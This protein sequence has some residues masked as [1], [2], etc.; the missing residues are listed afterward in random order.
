MK[1]QYYWPCFICSIVFVLF[2]AGCEKQGQLTLRLLSAPIDDPYSELDELRLTVV[3]KNFQGVAYFVADPKQTSVEVGDIDSKDNH[4]ILITGLKNK[5]IIAT[6]ASRSLNL[7]SGIESLEIIPFAS[8]KVAVAIPLDF[9]SVSSNSQV[10]ID[11][12]PSIVM[13][14]A[15][16]LIDGPAVSNSDLRVEMLFAWNSDAIH[17]LVRVYDDCP[18]LGAHHICD[19]ADKPDYLALGFNGSGTKNSSYGPGDFWIRIDPG[20][21]HG[22]DQITLL[23]SNP[24]FTDT[25]KQH[26]INEEIEIA[27]LIDKGGWWSIEGSVSLSALNRGTITTN[28][29]IGFD[30]VVFDYDP[31]QT[32]PTVFRWSRISK[33]IITTI[34]ATPPNLMGTLGFGTL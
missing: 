33:D 30:L 27:A 23:Q 14:N 16:N 17:F 26:L 11:S 12:S 29:D 13:D 18:D 20:A 7:K 2:W 22:D 34:E 25:E 8:D 32:Q 31:G 6:G 28:D 3:D 1:K 5:E 9:V 24:S 10:K 4:R 15:R 19:S 21:G